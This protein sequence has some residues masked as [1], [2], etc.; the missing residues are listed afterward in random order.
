MWRS[1]LGPWDGMPPESREALRRDLVAVG[2]RSLLM[3]L[4]TALGA[5]L[6][7]DLAQQAGNEDGVAG[8]VAWLYTSSFVGLLLGPLYLRFGR[9]FSPMALLRT[10]ELT[11]RTLLLVCALLGLQPWIEPAIAFALVVGC[12]NAIAMLST[13]LLSQIYGAFYSARDR[14][15]VIGFSRLVQS[16]VSAIGMYAIG[17]LLQEAAWAYQIVYPA[18]AAIGM[19]I[20][21][22]FC[23]LRVGNVQVAVPAMGAGMLRVLIENRNFRNFQIFQMILGAANLGAAPLIALFVKDELTGLSVEER[24]L[25]VNGGIASMLVAVVSVRGHGWMFDRV[26]VLQHRVI[27]SAVMGTGYLVWAFAD[28][29]VPAIVAASLIGFGMAGGGIVWT[30]GALYFAEPDQYRTYTSTHTFLTGVRGIITPPLA[31]ALWVATGQDY[32]L[33]FLIAAGMIGVSALGHQ[34]ATRLTPPNADVEGP[35][36]EPELTAHDDKS[37]AGNAR[38]A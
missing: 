4:F 10:S 13:P 12:A 36:V 22:Y 37:R 32:R 6:C 28:G 14:G 35:V 21:L 16:L 5:Q 8:W 33:I 29:L 27:C 15:K 23:R 31:V 30:I 20:T 11:S 18:I 3:A 19:V 9:R 24:V 17:R 26:G 34:F 25:V 1:L 2:V 7:L 38:G